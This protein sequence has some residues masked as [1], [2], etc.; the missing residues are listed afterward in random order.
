MQRFAVVAGSTILGL[1]TMLNAA[2][3]AYHHQIPVQAAMLPPTIAPAPVSSAPISE[4]NE[5]TNSRGEIVGI[6]RRDPNDLVLGVTGPDGSHDQ[7]IGQQDSPT[8]DAAYHQ[9]YADA[10]A[11]ER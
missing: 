4:Y 8:L 5:V 7:P 6:Y 10:R 2:V 1:L 3:Y 9:I 11:A